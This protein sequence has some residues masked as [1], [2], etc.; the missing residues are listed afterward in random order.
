V[1]IQDPQVS[2]RHALI[3]AQPDGF[4]FFDLGSV[5][6]RYL[7]G[8]RITTS[9]LLKT[10][11]DVKTGTHFYLFEGSGGVAVDESSTAADAPM[12]EGRS[13]EAILLVCDIQRFTTLSEKL[14]PNELAP[15]IGSW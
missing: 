10:G 15:I 9:L 11:E 12:V 4:W 13:H 8:R 7:N 14:D 3:R 6:G 5:N 2:R 1:V